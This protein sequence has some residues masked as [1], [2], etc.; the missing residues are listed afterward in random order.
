MTAP[1]T[2]C[3]E[4]KRGRGEDH[5]K[6]CSIGRRKFV[7][8]GPYAPLPDVG[9]DPR[10]FN[11]RAHERNNMIAAANNLHTPGEIVK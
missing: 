5:M 3:P 8:A 1:W 11:A 2:I 10:V 9:V 7:A 4:C 6:K